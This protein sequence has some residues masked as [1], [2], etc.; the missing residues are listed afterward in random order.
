MNGLVSFVLYPFVTVAGWLCNRIFR[1]AFGLTSLQVYSRIMYLPGIG[2]NAISWR[3]RKHRWYDRIDN[4]VVLG[5][6][7]LRSQTEEVSGY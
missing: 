1:M 4:T 5:A 2:W 3:W 7:P 6:L